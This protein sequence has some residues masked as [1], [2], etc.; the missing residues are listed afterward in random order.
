MSLGK[1]SRDLFRAARDGG[2]PSSSDRERVR[3]A[4]D[5]RIAAGGTAAAVGA[6]A[7]KTAAGTA[8]LGGAGGTAI[9]IGTLAKVVLP[10]V[11]LGAAIAAATVHGVRAGRETVS[12]PSSPSSS[13]SVLRRSVAERDR[14]SLSEPEPDTPAALAAEPS[15]QKTPQRVGLSVTRGPPL[16][17]AARRADKSSSDRSEVALLESMNAALARGDA[18][19]TLALAY[20]HARLYPQGTLAQERDGARALALCIVGTT[21]AAKEFV[22]AHPS[23]PL[24]G[25][26]RA[27]CESRADS[28]KEAPPPGQ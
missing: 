6:L 19:A 26:L 27:V 17:E 3:G 7:T 14:V 9:A 12:S 20:E 28:I 25:R 5:K 15:P 11:V 24:V 4:I 18:Q 10:V 16:A 8:G 2:K 21:S 13:S 23:S 22:A 1:P